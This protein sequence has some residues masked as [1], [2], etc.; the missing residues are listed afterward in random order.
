MGGT[1]AP[2]RRRPRRRRRPRGADVPLDRERRDA[3]S[4]ANA[5]N[6]TLTCTTAGSVTVTLAVSDVDCGG[7]A[8][9]TV[10]LHRR[11]AHRHQRGRIERRSGRRL[12]RAE[13]NAG[14]TT[15]GTSGLEA[16]GQR[17]HPPLRGQRP[18]RN[19]A[20]GGWPSSAIYGKFQTFG[21]GAPDSARLYD[22]AGN[23]VDSYSWTTHAV[24]TYGRCP[25]GTGS[26]SSDSTPTPGAPATPAAAEL[27]DFERRGGRG[28][29]AAPSAAR[30]RSDPGAGGA[31]GA[32]AGGGGTATTSSSIVNE[33]EIERRSGRRTGWS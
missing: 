27:A 33:V 23:L 21:L 22:P 6:P 19:V 11:R 3:Y 14:T 9:T 7:S 32:G 26:P 31:A 15:A 1:I 13:L 25:D 20:G 28:A 10:T 5:Q 4:D 30:A 8:S 18:E 29:G 12:G 2:G 24:G 16:P 17:R